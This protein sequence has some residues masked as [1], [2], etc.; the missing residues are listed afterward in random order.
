MTNLLLLLFLC[1]SCFSSWGD[2]SSYHQGCLRH[3]AESM[4]TDCEYTCMWETVDVMVGRHDQV[5]QFYGKWPFQRVLWLS[6]PAS[7]LASLAQFL[8]S[9]FALHQIT[10]HLPKASPLRS[11]WRLHTSTVAITSLCSF[12]HH[13]RETELFELLDSISSVLVVTS[14]LALLAHRA[15]AG[16]H[17]KLIFLATVALFV[18]HLVSVVLLRPDHHHLFQVN[19]VISATHVSFW[20]A[21]ILF[22]WAEGPHMMVGLLAILL[23]LASNL[24]SLLNFPP[25]LWLVDSQALSHL[26]SAPT[27]LLWGNF[28]VSDCLLLQRR[29]LVAR[30]KLE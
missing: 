22:N 17:G 1:K 15:L 3:C 18:A 25:L 2:S 29:R 7:S 26:V 30:G 14:S 4:R 28:A 9:I 13:G 11:A 10:S 19:F 23:T 20:T 12:L 16:K 27:P 6:E 8:C 5:P 24:L 21:W